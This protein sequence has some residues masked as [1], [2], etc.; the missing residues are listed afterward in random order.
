MP[1][2]VTFIDYQEP[3]FVT[4]ANYIK[5][6]NHAKEFARQGFEI[7]EIVDPPSISNGYTKD[8]GMIH[9]IERTGTHGRGRKIGIIH[10]SVTYGES[11]DKISEFWKFDIF[12][13]EYAETFK[14]LA[15]LIAEKFNAD[16]LLSQRYMSTLEFLPSRYTTKA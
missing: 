1:G 3:T 13:A 6:I 8:D 14:I 7:I 4:V 5:S 16:I 2:K 12:G 10:I 9:L 11:G 15:G